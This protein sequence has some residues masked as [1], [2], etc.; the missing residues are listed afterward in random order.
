[1]E[2]LVGTPGVS[3]AIQ[4]L[5]T[6]IANSISGKICVQLVTSRGEAGKL[7]TCGNWGDFLAQLGGYVAGAEENA[8]MAK[9]ALEHGAVLII[10]RALHYDDIDVLTPDGDKAVATI[11]ESTN[12]I[13][14]EAL[15]VGDGYNG[16]TLETKA[17]KSGVTG[18]LDL[19]INLK[20]SPNEIEITGIDKDAIATADIAALNAKLSSQGAQ[21]KITSIANEIPVG[22]ASLASGDITLASIVAADWNGSDVAK[23]GWHAFDSVADSMRIMNFNKADADVD[24]DLAAYVTARKDM[25]AALRTPLGLNATSLAAYLAGTTPYSHTAIDSMFVDYFYTD[26]EITDP[27]DPTVRDKVISLLGHYAG[28]KSIS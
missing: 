5:S 12:T 16:T 13:S 22:T 2:N 17:S 9:A 1:M 4:D 19:I 27:Q 11:T 21:L 7:Y 15:G 10:T 14:F 26:G 25:R 3:V 20:D 8:I 23:N 6:I 28:F 24:T 18:E